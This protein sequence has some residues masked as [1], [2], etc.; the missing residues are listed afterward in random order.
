M[1][2]EWKFA[3]RLTSSQYRTNAHVTPCRCSTPTIFFF[4]LLSVSQTANQ[5]LPRSEEKARNNRGGDILIYPLSLRDR[6]NEADT[7]LMDWTETENT[8]DSCPAL[9]P[10]P[11]GA[12]RMIPARSVS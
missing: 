2:R 6:K 5:S 8:T 3:A 9:V 4:L 12:G 1:A 7:C 11:F 10:S